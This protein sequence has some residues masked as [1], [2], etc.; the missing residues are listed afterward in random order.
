[1]AAFSEATSR[2]VSSVSGLVDSF[3]GLSKTAIGLGAGLAAFGGVVGKVIGL[4]LA[5]VGA[6]GAAA[7]GIA[8]A[9][10]NLA[11][12][13]A[14]N[15]L[16]SVDKAFQIL[17]GTIGS[18]VLPGVIMLGGVALAASGYIAAWV[19]AHKTDIIKFWTEGVISAT[20]AVIAFAKEMNKFIPDK[21]EE[22]GAPE[23]ENMFDILGPIGRMMKSDEENRRLDEELE[24][25]KVAPFVG[26]GPVNW[27]LAG[28]PVN[29]Q[30]PDMLKGRR[31]LGAGPVGGPGQNPNFPQVAAAD[32][33]KANKFLMDVADG[34]K[35]VIKDMRSS[36]GTS[37]IND[38]VNKWKEVAMQI[39]KSDLDRQMLAN[40]EKHLKLAEAAEGWL[41]QI[42]GGGA[43]AVAGP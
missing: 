34:M 1:M 35:S 16:G 36:M 10:L 17:A 21:P 4:P 18:I 14:P 20:R 39:Q 2:A 24:R 38:P 7:G 37:G 9:G 25:A 12:A 5:A 26:M 22:L 33:P 43:P 23:S 30:A 31:E 40:Q 3:R 13:A 41:R 8:G 27:R 19:D 29:G 15:G 42:A 32:A 11:G 6:A 28:K